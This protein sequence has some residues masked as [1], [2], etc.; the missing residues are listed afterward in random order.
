MKFFLIGT[1]LVSSALV[2]GCQN[3][4]RDS[5]SVEAVF[6]ESSQ[7]IERDILFTT[8]TPGATHHVEAVMLYKSG[9][10][11]SQFGFWL[12]ETHYRGYD[13]WVLERKVIDGKLVEN[14]TAHS[15]ETGRS[16]S[17]GDNPTTLDLKWL[18]KFRATAWVHEPI[19]KTDRKRL[20]W[21]GEKNLPIRSGNFF[22]LEQTID[23]VSKLPER[24][25]T[26]DEKGLPV[27]L[28]Q[29]NQIAKTDDLWVPVRFSIRNF[30]VDEVI[31]VNIRNT[32]K[33]EQA[34]TDSFSDLIQSRSERHPPTNETL[35]ASDLQIHSL[36]VL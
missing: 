21:Q 23:T 18:A 32:R 19:V 3:E 13:F 36:S 34:A 28:I 30:Q 27:Q 14:W 9:E 6:K 26:G 5:T 33:L 11:S 22:S 12:T 29:V 10:N 2:S 31:R 35:G 4:R 25:E 20:S 15:T 24:Y 17:I 1:V 16:Q 7:V 8:E